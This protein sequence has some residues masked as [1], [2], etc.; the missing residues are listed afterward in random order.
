MDD[1]LNESLTSSGVVE[2]ERGR[3]TGTS[4]RLNNTNGLTIRCIDR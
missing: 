3:A 1:V 2:R 4:E